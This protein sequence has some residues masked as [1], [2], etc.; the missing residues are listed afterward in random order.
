MCERILDS[1][2]SLP[3]REYASF[4]LTS[5]SSCCAEMLCFALLCWSQVLSKDK[6]CSALLS[7]ATPQ[8]C[9][10]SAFINI[11]WLNFSSELCFDIESVRYECQLLFAPS[12]I[13]IIWPMRPNSSRLHTC[14]S[15][16]QTRQQCP[17]SFFIILDRH[18]GAR[19][20]FRSGI[21]HAFCT[22]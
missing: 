17:I 20:S 3:A 12:S 1:A 22:V 11:D 19:D 10:I 8:N 9:Q 5:A 18:S 16:P 21:L 4:A 15:S 7:I 2:S 6:H 14:A 13:C